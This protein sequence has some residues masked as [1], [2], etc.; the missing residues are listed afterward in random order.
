MT[1]KQIRALYQ[2]KIHPG[3]T[4]EFLLEDGTVLDIK[5]FSVRKI[6]K[7]EENGDFKLIAPPKLT[8]VLA[9]SQPDEP[10]PET[11]QPTER[12]PD[13]ENV[14]RLT[15]EDGRTITV[16]EGKGF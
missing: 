5:D 8:V 6:T 2:L 4:L 13:S 1:D 16:S 10:K 11:P 12:V 9:K 7:R 3:S 15:Y 14:T